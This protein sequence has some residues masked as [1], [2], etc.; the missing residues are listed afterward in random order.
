MD[1]APETMTFADP[2]YSLVPGED[3]VLNVTLLDEDAGEVVDTVVNFTV[4]S[5]DGDLSDASD[6]TNGSGVASTELTANATGTISVE[7]YW[8]DGTI[9]VADTID[10]TV[11]DAPDQVTLNPPTASIALNADQSL[12]ARALRSG[13]GVPGVVLSFEVFPG[14]DGSLSLIHI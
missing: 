3:V 7:A 9:E 13:A 11:I 4:L 6:A 8:T 14:L 2:G 1:P 12:T 5:G 10:I